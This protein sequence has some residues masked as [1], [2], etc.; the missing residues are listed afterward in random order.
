MDFFYSYSCLEVAQIS[1]EKSFDE[2]PLDPSVLT[3]SEVV[4]SCY[5]KIL[6]LPDFFLQ[7]KGTLSV[8][9]QITD[10]PSSNEHSQPN[11][12]NWAIHT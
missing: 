4:D 12:I 2:K 5:Q 6:Q 10:P 1:L 11:P 8:L 3:S 7:K 9:W